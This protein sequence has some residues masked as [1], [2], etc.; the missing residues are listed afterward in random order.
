MT[1]QDPSPPKL[2]LRFFRW[3]CHPSLLAAI[4]GDLMELYGER[5]RLSGKRK[6][7][8][9]FLADVIL[10]FRPGIIRPAGGHQSLNKYGMFKSYLTIAWRNLLKAKGYSLINIGGLAIGMA[11]AILIGLWLHYELTFNHNFRNYERIARVMKNQEF[12]GVVETWGTQPKQLGP[13]L[14][15]AYGANFRHVV[16]SGGPDNHKLTHNSKTVRYTGNFMDPAATEMLELKMIE[17]T[18]DGLTDPHSVLLSASAAKAI[19]GNDDPMNAMLTLNDKNDIKVTGIYEDLPANCDFAGVGFIVPFELFEK[20]N[21]PDWLGWGNS[22][23]QCFVQLEDGVDMESASVNIRDAIAK[24]ARE[25]G[26]KFKPQLFLHPMDSWHLFYVFENGVVTG[27][28][29][30]YVWMFGSIGALVLLLACINFMNLSTARSERRAREVGIRKSV[31]SLQAQLVKQFYI[32]SFLIVG[33]ALLIA[34]VL[35]QV[36]LPWF[37]AVSGINVVIPWGSLAFWVVL[38]GFATVVGLISGSYPAF[39]LSSFKP[40]RALKGMLKGGRGSTLPRKVMV[41]IQFSISVVLITGTFVIVKQIDH[42]RNRPIGY[43]KDGLISSPV[44]TD[45]IRQHIDAFSNDLRATGAVSSVALTDIDITNTGTTNSGFSWKGKP[46]DM[47]E[48]FWTL[49]VTPDFGTLMKWDLVA[50]RDFKAG[51]STSFIINETAAKYMGMA[52][53]LGEVVRWGGNGEFKIIGVVKDMVTRSPYSPVKQ[54][55]FFIP[56]RLSWFANANIRLNPEMNVVDAIS[57]VESVFRKYDPD[58]AF[59]YSFVSERYANKFN[60]ERRIAKL[61]SGLAGLG[62][63]ICCLGLFGLASFVAERRTKE[64]GIRKVLGA[65][66]GGLWRMM[67]K[68]FILLVGVAGVI[69]VPVAYYLSSDWLSQFEYRVNLSWYIFVAATGGALLIALVTVS[70]H[71]LRLAMSNPVGALRSE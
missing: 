55:I 51:D 31:G 43:E 26:D 1:V 56:Q 17:G 11:A 36:T 14:R 21:L 53:P 35:A 50:G 41:V 59:E 19:F 33:I 3:Y 20:E 45:N 5:V 12:N 10:L 34:V 57:R 6:A 54:M 49:R 38:A 62:I 15:G 71:A 69:A 18:R 24:N 16:R 48:Q 70:Y 30:R 61:S 65:S 44:R 39:Y 32:E 52:S 4:E 46:D 68:D 67:S 40:V 8:L 28:G 7:D 29:I 47:Q 2:I 27:G 60:N 66:V 13:E 23:F 63:F 22:W 9:N 42:A 25:I 37:R 58:N 64:V